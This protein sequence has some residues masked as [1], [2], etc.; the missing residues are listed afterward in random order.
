V[1]LVVLLVLVAAGCGGDGN[2]LARSCRGRAV[3]NCL[4]YEYSVVTEASL[5]PG[6]ISVG[7]PGGMARIRVVLDTCGAMAPDPHEVSLSARADNPMGLPDS[8]SPPAVFFLTEVRDNGLD[9]DAT[10]KDGMIDVMVGNPFI[11]PEVPPD[12]DIVIRFQPRAGRTC[13]GESLE[14]PY[15][16]G[17]RFEPPMP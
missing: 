1:R 7:D 8:G 16:T 10:A 9:G 17:P 11:G 13:T 2:P 5:E 12:E 6:M 14:I 4:P 3:P 15:R